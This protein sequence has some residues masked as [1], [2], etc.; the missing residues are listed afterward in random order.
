MTVTSLG[1]RTKARSAIC[2]M[3]ALIVGELALAASRAQQPQPENKP[4]ERPAPPPGRLESLERARDEVALREIQWET[5]KAELRAAEASL[6]I[7]E[8][9]L[10][11]LEARADRDSAIGKANTMQAEVRVSS[12]KAT[13]AAKEAAV[14]QAKADL[15]ATLAAR[16]FHKKVLERYKRLLSSKAISDREYHEAEDR[17][18][19]AES[20]VHSAQSGVFHAKAEVGE[21]AAA[22]DQ[23]KADALKVNQ[24]DNPLMEDARDK[25]ESAKA[26]SD[27]SRSR[28]RE[29]GLRLSQAKHRLSL[30]ESA[31]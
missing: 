15:E 12:A 22:I 6:R 20:R 11:R 17:L 9:E 28:V 23:A 19:V 18:A 4:G 10:R 14:G 1:T 13:L 31:K 30:I 24:V 7:V 29:A 16:E 26:Q 2:I 8:R 21:A 3:A 25:F 27:A 5:R